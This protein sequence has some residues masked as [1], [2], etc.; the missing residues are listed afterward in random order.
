[1]APRTYEMGRRAMASAETRRRIVDAAIA[2][3]AEKG[4]LGT[5]WADIARQA[6]VAV[7]TVY[8]Y[9]PSHD[10]L[11]PACTSENARRTRPPSSAMLAGATSPDRRVGRLVAEIFAYYERS[12]P[13]IPRANI[14]RREL[15]VLDTILSQREARFQALVAESL[16][17]L[18]RR[19][20]A[21]PAAM[22]L[23]DFGVWK[24]LNAGGLSTRAA[25]ELITDILM[26]WLNA[27]S[28][29]R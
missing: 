29:H 23:T 10:E 19:R 5:S 21:L 25:A 6:D 7:G 4:V 11:V 17:P 1:M 18:R 14:D 24:S 26:S 28:K 12:A 8:R 3:H 9:F 22:A 13:W 16:G 15:P 20:S 2:I 27:R